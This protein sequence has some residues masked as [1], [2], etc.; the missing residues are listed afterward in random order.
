MPYDCREAE[1][2][3]GSND[4]KTSSIVSRDPWTVSFTYDGAILIQVNRDSQD[5]V[6]QVVTLPNG[7]R[8]AVISLKT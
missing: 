6:C 2:G 5:L 4:S 8:A 1:D 7:R 3:F